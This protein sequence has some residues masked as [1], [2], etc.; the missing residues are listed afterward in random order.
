M[1]AI[2]KVYTK[3]DKVIADVII[4]SLTTP[5]HKK[6][7]KDCINSLRQ[8]ESQHHFNVILIESSQSI[9]ELGQNQTLKAPVPFNYNKA[10]DSGIK[11]SN[12]EWVVMANNDLLFEKNWFSEI[13][14]A[15]QERPDIKSF[16][17]WNNIGGWH[18]TRMPQCED[19]REGYG[20]GY[21]LCGWILAIRR[22]D[23]LKL[24]IVN[25]VAF[26]CSDNV[27][28]DELQRVGFKH[29]LVKKSVVNHLTSKTLLSGK[30]DVKDLTEGQVKNYE[31]W[32]SNINI[33]QT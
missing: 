8:S 12:S 26:W 25:D 10:L 31:N 6:M 2:K 28:S 18:Q 23:Y 14:K 16:S 24:N 21:E 1:P 20:I 19:I 4:P 29:A 11:I 13:L 7:V 30:V 22:S 27:Y 17:S 32:R 9:R 5:E 33:Q 15:S 3:N